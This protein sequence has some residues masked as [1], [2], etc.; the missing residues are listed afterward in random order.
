MKQDCRE[1]H[2]SELT[3]PTHTS[4][5]QDRL[6]M[7]LPA[8]ADGAHIGEKNKAAKAQGSTHP[9]A[10]CRWPV[11]LAAQFPL[12]SHRTTEW[13][14]WKG[15][16]RSQNYGI[17]RLTSSFSPS[18]TQSMGQTHIHNLSAPTTPSSLHGLHLQLLLCF[19]LQPSHTKPALALISPALLSCIDT[20]EQ[21][22]GQT[23][24]PLPRP[25][26]FCLSAGSTFEVCPCHMIFV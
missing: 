17:P 20:K 25:S 23:T 2:N 8:P 12:Q 1:Q 21:I 11:T 15:P 26:H 9:C 10:Q 7:G 4:P 16:S 14:S 18:R 13:L 19:H 24:S 3:L 6:S 22:C 5:P